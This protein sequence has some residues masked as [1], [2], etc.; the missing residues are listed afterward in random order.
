VSELDCIGW[1]LLLR[2]NHAQTLL[3]SNPNGN[4]KRKYPTTCGRASWRGFLY[5]SEHAR[6]QSGISL[7]LCSTGTEIRSKAQ[8]PKS[9]VNREVSWR[10]C[11]GG[12]LL[13]RINLKLETDN[14]AA[15]NGL[16]SLV[17]S[18]KRI[19]AIVFPGHMTR[20]GDVVGLGSSLKV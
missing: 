11:A 20:G 7:I 2:F 9:K 1:T 13:T 18:Y 15:G 5:S 17:V 6:A 14:E 3:Q 4:Q 16:E 8:N 12:L 10:T 19:C